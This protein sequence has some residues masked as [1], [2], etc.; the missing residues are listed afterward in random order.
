MKFERCSNLDCRRPFQVNEF[1][2]GGK[3]TFTTGYT[4]P[5]CGHVQTAFTNSVILVHALSEE[6]EV[7]FNRQYPL[8]HGVK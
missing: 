4:C 6:Q 2:F 7:E 5:H 3:E 8:E 1:D